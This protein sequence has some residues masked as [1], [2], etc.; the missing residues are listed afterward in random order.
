MGM[1]IRDTSLNALVS[2]LRKDRIAGRAPL[3]IT[4]QWSREIR[5]RLDANL[6]ATGSTGRGEATPASDLDV[7]RLSVGRTPRFDALR[8][9]GI[10]ADAHGALPVAGELPDTEEQWARE[11]QDWLARPGD[12]KGVVKTGLLADA[13][14]EVRSAASRGFASSP[15]LA[16]MLRD[17]LSVIPPRT[18]GLWSRKSVDLKKEI[19][20]PT[21]KIAR[22]AAL[23]S[24]SDELSTPQRLTTS[25]PEFLDKDSAAG[26]SGAFR[27]AFSLAVDLDF[28][29][30]DNRIFERSGRVMLT[31]LPSERRAMLQSAT[32]VLRQVSATLRYLLSTSTFNVD[33]TTGG[34]NS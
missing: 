33:S 10:R 29:I 1:A 20:V 2:Q 9:A 16:D 17:A 15:I 32:Q 27:G 30:A 19:L 5:D 28:G 34:Q 31:A 26:L 3:E 18:T 4:S 23:A 7:I 13:H 12:N 21:S 22:W 6:A 24:G 8:S 14:A 11:A 25:N